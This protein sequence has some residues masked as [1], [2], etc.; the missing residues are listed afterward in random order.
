MLRLLLLGIQLTSCIAFLEAL[1]NF[2]NFNNC[3][4]HQFSCKNEKCI[5]IMSRCDGK[6]DCGDNSDEQHCDLYLCREPSFFRCQNN[7]CIMK[8]L[9]CDGENDCL[10]YSDEK[11]CDSFKCMDKLCIP[12]E[13]VCNGVRD[14]LDD[15][16]EGTG[17]EEQGKTTCDEFRCGTGRCLPHQWRC[18]VPIAQCTPDNQKFLCSDNSTCLDIGRACNGFLDCPGGD[19]ESAMCTAPSNLATDTTVPT[20][21]GNC[22]RDPDASVLQA[23]PG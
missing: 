23:I 21:V 6:D 22:L 2:G 7:R 13:W 5:S 12:H 18:H 11:N 14:C 4:I 19:D 17:C 3:T 8:R 20:N 15:S 16:D 10:D 9:V 1:F